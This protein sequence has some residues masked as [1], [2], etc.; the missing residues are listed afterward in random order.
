MVGGRGNDQVSKEA[1][2]MG[3]GENFHQ[4]LKLFVLALAAIMNFF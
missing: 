4:A 1:G 3:K 2:G